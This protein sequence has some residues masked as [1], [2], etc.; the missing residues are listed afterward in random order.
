MLRI[1]LNSKAAAALKVNGWLLPGNY[2]GHRWQLPATDGYNVTLDGNPINLPP[3]IGHAEHNV[4]AFLP[5]FWSQVV[6]LS[7][8]IKATKKN[9]RLTLGLEGVA[10]SIH[11]LS[12]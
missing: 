9:A 3:S 11:R 12:P 8:S 7:C 4:P 2:V 10:D 6:R 1:H 5:Y